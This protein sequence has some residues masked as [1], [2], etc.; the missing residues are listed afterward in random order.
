MRGGWGKR[1][2]LLES[3]VPLLTRKPLIQNRKEKVA[4]SRLETIKDISEKYRKYI[5][6]LILNRKFYYTVYCAEINEQL[7]DKILVDKKKILCF[8]RI[9]DLIDYLTNNKIA[10]I[11]YPTM[12][13]WSNKM[14]N[15]NPNV[16]D[17]TIANCTYN[18]DLMRNI[19]FDP[20]FELSELKKKESLEFIDF[21]NLFK[22]YADQISYNR[23]VKLS[24]NKDIRLVWN[25]CY[26][27]YFWK[28]DE[29]RDFRNLNLVKINR[30]KFVMY[31][32][33][34]YDCFTKN[35]LIVK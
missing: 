34:I 9:R 24:N 13:K 30:D 32:Q 23:Y 31:M 21:I 28:H 2:F 15:L 6:R 7:T 18:L 25:F 33:K 17:K 1:R 35:I 5:I 8:R 20:N 14:V 3:R 29:K 27:R 16:D 26:D 19:Y 12:L 22:D 11:D 10:G 4:M